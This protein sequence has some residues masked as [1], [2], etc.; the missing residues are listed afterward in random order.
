M[1]VDE[2][3]PAARA[4]ARQGLVDAFGHVSARTASGF[5]MTPPVPLGRLSGAEAMIDVE[6]AGED[7]PAGAPKEA[8]IH[9]AIYARRPDVRAVCRATPS[10]VNQAGGAGVVL[11]AL[12]GQGAFVGADVP[13]YDDAVLVRD[14]R[15]GEAVAT[16]LGGGDAVVLRGNGA[17]TIAASPGIAVALMY[18]LEAS[19]RMNLAAASTGLA[20]PLAEHECAAW[21]AAAP[22]ILARLWDY[23]RDQEQCAARE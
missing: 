14:A 23:L 6:V 2:V 4:L 16:A 22:E 15:R 18:V 3:L 20:R 5:A 21:R 17:V 11:R 13:V 1:S 7:L 12:H 8:W 19:A 9:R 10:A